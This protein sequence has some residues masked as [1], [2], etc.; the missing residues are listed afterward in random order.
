MRLNNRLDPDRYLANKEY[1]DSG[2]IL[3]L[4]K[5]NQK[6]IDL[7]LTISA[8][9]LRHNQDLYNLKTLRVKYKELLVSFK[10]LSN[11]GSKLTD[12]NK[13]FQKEIKEIYKIL[14]EVIDSKDQTIKEIEK[15]IDEKDKLIEELKR[16]LNRYEKMD[17]TNS[18]NPKTHYYP[19]ENIN[20]DNQEDEKD[21]GSIKVKT[22]N[23]VIRNRGGKLNHTA[24]HSKLAKPDKIINRYVNTYPKSAKPVYDKSGVISY[25]RTQEI[26]ISLETRVIETRY[27]IKPD[28]VDL[29]E[30]SKNKYRINHVTYSNHFKALTLYLETRGAIALDR[31][32]LILKELSSYEL[33]LQPSTIVKWKKE[34]F[35]RSKDYRD[36]LLAM[37]NSSYICHVDETGYKVAGNQGWIH[38][39]CNDKFSY[40]LMSDKRSDKDYGP[41][42][43]LQEY[44]NILVHDHFKPYYK[45]LTNCE[46]SECN[47][48]I[49]RYLKAGIDFDDLFGCQEMID[50]LKKALHK[51]YELI[52]EG[53]DK[54]PIEILDSI[55]NKYLEICDKEI[56][57]YYNNH[58]DIKAKYVP[59]GIKTLKRM[60]EYIDEHLRFLTDFS[61]PY[62]NNNAERQC[63]I[64]KAH[65][66]ISGQVQNIENGNYLCALLTVSQTSL[67]QNKNTLECFENIITTGWPNGKTLSLP[68]NN[69]V[70][71]NF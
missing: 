17:S 31:L 47:A 3:C 29:D 60:R 21:K 39:L 6:I 38:V 30:T 4:E 69:S 16:K 13:D 27:Y 35:L 66:K 8:Y 50:L 28:Y 41:I 34:F 20:S 10:N 7:E 25:Y 57:A 67:L 26:D 24:H 1:F 48:H 18:N 37:I 42:K 36:W 9:K 68:T 22:T 70:P 54:I 55:K 19:F 11:K 33:S 40:F 43:L 52:Q 61:V 63:R 59:E 58:P 65:K 51:K 2:L 71:I 53:K 64:V 56:E 49:E 5:A 62:S 15:Q 44:V 32:C 14:D 45:Y 23:R 12:D 46:H